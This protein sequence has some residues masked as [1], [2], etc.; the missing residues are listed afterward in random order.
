MTYLPH[1]LAAVVLDQY[2]DNVKEII[3]LFRYCSF[4]RIRNF[5]NID[6]IMERYSGPENVTINKYKQHLDDN[7]HQADTEPF[8]YKERLK[9]LRL[10]GVKNEFREISKEK[11]QEQTSVNCWNVKVTSPKWFF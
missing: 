8:L 11:T 10:L 6:A 2:M 3:M 5:Q 4:V 1:L 9:A 7:C